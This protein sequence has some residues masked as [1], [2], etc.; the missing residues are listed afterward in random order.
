[1]S[2]ALGPLPGPHPR[3]RALLLTATMMLL[4]GGAPRAEAAD[5]FGSWHGLSVKVLDAD[6][7]ALSQVAQLRFRD[8]SSELFAR[9]LS[10]QLTYS[11]SPRLRVGL[12]YTV[13]PA[14]PVDSNDF[15]AQRRW[16]LEIMPRWSAG[17]RLVID[18]RS[19]LEL[20]WLEG[21]AGRNE[22]SRHQPQVTFRIGGSGRL[23][24]VYANNEIF[25]DHD[26]HRL[27]EN[28]F[29]PLGLSFRLTGQGSVS[30]QYMLQSVRGNHG[31]SQS[32]V[33]VTQ[34]SLAL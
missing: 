25:Y 4:G 22:R 24:S 6:G 34:L 13:L 18:W 5:D 26:A 23:Q 8:D 2:V 17:D 14:R 27:T 15:R 16:E 28:R 10:S 1:M 20:R 3:Y 32:H 19:R 12:N 31:W 30:A 29:V 7:W 21:R 9:L 11:A 33:L